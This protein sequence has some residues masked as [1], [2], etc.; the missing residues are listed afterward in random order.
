VN[1]HL[2]IERLVVDG[3][4]LGQHGALDLQSVLSEALRSQLGVPG[5]IGY[6]S[7]GSLPTLECARVRLPARAD[8]GEVGSAA[9]QSL[10]AG[11]RA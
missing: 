8:A 6:T 9:A 10:A 2:H 4:E 5:A 1:V 7:S 11:L 3:I